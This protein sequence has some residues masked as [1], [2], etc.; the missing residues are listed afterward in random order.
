M[1]PPRVL[2]VED[3]QDIAGLIKHTLERSGD[4]T[5]EI[6][7][8]GDEALRS[9]AGRP[10]DLIHPP[11]G[12]RFSPRCPYAQDRCREEEPPLQEAETP[13]HLY[14]C[15][16][17]VG[18]PEGADAL[19]RNRAA[20]AGTRAPDAAVSTPTSATPTPAEA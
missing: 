17:P 6:I 10:P 2:V 14:A 13:G 12:C 16:Y 8:R 7:G 3:E 5:V 19:A 18:T 20:L 15:W 9:I 1:V 4:A 11:K